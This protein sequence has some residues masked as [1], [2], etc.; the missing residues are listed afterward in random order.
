MEETSLRLSLIIHYLRWASGEVGDETAVDKESVRAAISLTE[1]FKHEWRRFHLVLNESDIEHAERRLVKWVN[2]KGGTVTA[3]EVQMGCRWLR[4]PGAADAA[5]EALAKAG[6]GEWEPTPAGQ[7]GQPTR[8]FRLF[9][10]PAVNSN[11][12]FQAENRIPLT[13]DNVDA[14][15]NDVEI[16]L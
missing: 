4:E 10:P 2:H 8:R 12:E 11:S 15:E 3:R 9:E 1:W 5:L 6:R 16:D 14:F 7:R 13:V